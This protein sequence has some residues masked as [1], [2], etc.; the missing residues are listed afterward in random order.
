MENKLSKSW[1]KATASGY[2]TVGGATDSTPQINFY[3]FKIPYLTILCLGIFSFGTSLFGSFE[4]SSTLKFVFSAL[5]FFSVLQIT[6]EALIL[7]I[8]QLAMEHTDPLSLMVLALGSLSVFV[9]YL[10]LAK[11]EFLSPQL[12]H[13]HQKTM[14]GMDQNHQNTM[15][16]MDQNHQKTMAEMEQNHQKT[17]A[18]IEYAHKE[19]LRQMEISQ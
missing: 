8:F 13:N 16:G 9:G 6:M 10:I 14:A 12:A 11:L 15:A 17:M 3:A 5:I 7:L 1:P 4:F 18:E 2:A 19:H